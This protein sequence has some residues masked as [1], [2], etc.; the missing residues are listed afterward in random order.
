M[1]SEERARL[2]VL[3]SRA[4][5]TIAEREESA[6][7]IA[8]AVEWARLGA[9]HSPDDENVVARLI[10]MLDLSGDRMGALNTYEGL[11]V[12][13]REEFGVA[14]SKETQ[15]LISAILAR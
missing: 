2:R 4:A 13:L 7:N 9:A 15:A 10:R 12:R 6:G 3:A 1:V 11:R 14:P 5:T 8:K